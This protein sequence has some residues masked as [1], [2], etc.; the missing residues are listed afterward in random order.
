[1]MAKQAYRPGSEA[2]EPMLLKRE[3]DL[4]AV[5]KP[6]SVNSHLLAVARG[7]SLKR[8]C[9]AHLVKVGSAEPWGPADMCLHLRTG[10]LN[11]MATNSLEAMQIKSLQYSCLT[12]IK[13][14]RVTALAN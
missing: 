7:G 14:S 12:A 3:P 13:R 5:S 2:G 11:R 1:M 6:L 4:S 10:L 8:L 9:G